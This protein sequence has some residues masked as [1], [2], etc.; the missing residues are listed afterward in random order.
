M[1]RWKQWKVCE[2][3]KKGAKQE[4]ALR[5]CSAV[6]AL[7]LSAKESACFYNKVGATFALE[8]PPYAAVLIPSAASSD[9][10]IPI[11]FLFFV[12]IDLYCSQNNFPAGNLLSPPHQKRDSRGYGGSS[13]GRQTKARC[14]IV[15]G[16]LQFAI[17]NP[18]RPLLIEK[19]RFIKNSCKC[20]AAVLFV[21]VREHFKRSPHGDRLTRYSGRNKRR[22]PLSLCAKNRLAGA[23]QSRR[24]QNKSALRFYLLLY[25]NKL[26][27]LL[28]IDCC[29]S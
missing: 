1:K 20:E 4:C 8:P 7:S 11:G 13:R 21:E 28:Y 23:L 29:C 27:F 10:S 19:E 6:R 22:S 9:C 25:I 16:N 3:R 17:G 18:P 26:S 12:S 2:E 15:L 14:A 5:Y 24:L